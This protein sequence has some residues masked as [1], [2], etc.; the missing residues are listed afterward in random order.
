MRVLIYGGSFNPPHRGHVEALRAAAETLKP[1]EILVIP[2]GMPPHKELAGGSPPPLERLRLCQ[3]AFG[4][5]PG[6]SVSDLEFRRDGKSY[7]VETLR[8]VAEEKPGAELYFQVGTDMLLSIESWYEFRELFG[9]CTLA[10]LPRNE[11][12]LP[13]LERF[14]GYLL[15][16][17]HEP[18]VLIRKPP[19]PMNSTALRESLPNRQGREL[20]PESV[21]SEI[22]RHRYYKAKPELAWLREK[23][24]AWLKPGRIPHV[25]GVEQEAVSLASF[26][27]EDTGEAA[28][29]GI[30][31]D[32][33]KKLTHDEQLRLCEKYGII[34]DAAERETKALLHQRTGAYLA[35]DLFGVSKNVFNAIQWHTTGR[36]HM[37]RLEEIVYLADFTE[38]NR[39]FP[40]VEEVR[41]LTYRDLDQA[42]IRALEM[43]EVDVRSKGAQPHERSLAALKWLREKD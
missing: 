34:T 9:L 28:E 43:S 23:T 3:L 10:V 35:R 5:I 14:C 11:G 7:T 4:D 12:D 37:T 26:W 15:E 41:A 6:V 1:D 18:S 22:I 27:G 25:R 31:H 36:A 24:D 38:P 2:A 16:T 30:L 29:A 17:Y 33:T 39:D 42:M 21:Y 19:L 13:E 8:Q 20:L 32:I 40:G